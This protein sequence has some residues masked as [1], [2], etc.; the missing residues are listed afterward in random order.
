MRSIGKRQAVLHNAPLRLLIGINPNRRMPSTKLGNTDESLK[1]SWSFL[2][3]SFN[4]S[5]VNLQNIRGRKVQDNKQKKQRGGG[6]YKKN[7]FLYLTY[8]FP[9]R[10]SIPPQLLLYLYT[11]LLGI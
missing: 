5:Q 9:I 7:S 1:A 11:K 2:W 6:V 4:S 10:S 8:N 3:Q